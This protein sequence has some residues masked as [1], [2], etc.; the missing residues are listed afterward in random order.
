ME[1]PAGLHVNY[2]LNPFLNL[3]AVIPD[4]AAPMFLGLS[5]AYDNGLTLFG[6]S[7]VA[8]L[9]Q[10]SS[11]NLGD[12]NFNSVSLPTSLLMSP[13]RVRCLL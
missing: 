5:A 2:R 4:L 8:D 9:A 1:Q 11:L 6:G 3:E 7:L 12:N 10:G 13:K